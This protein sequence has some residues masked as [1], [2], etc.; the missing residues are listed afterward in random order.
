MGPEQL[1]SKS[2]DMDLQRLKKINQLEIF[3]SSDYL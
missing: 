2:D 1:A 3:F